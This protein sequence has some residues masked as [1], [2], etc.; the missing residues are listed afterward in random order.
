M[1]YYPIY[2]LDRDSFS[3]R[4]LCTPN[5]L[6]FCEQPDVLDG[7][8]EGWTTNCNHFDVLWNFTERVPFINVSSSNDVDSF[9]EAVLNYERLCN[10]NKI[11]FFENYYN[12]KS[13]C[14]HKIL[15]NIIDKCK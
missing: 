5:D 10:N 2:L 8:F 12:N 9:L 14:N 13:L 11:Y 6:L 1:K 3:F 7:M 15:F 4:E